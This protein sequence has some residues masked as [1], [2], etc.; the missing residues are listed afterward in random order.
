MVEWWG[1]VWPQLSIS[2]VQ[3]SRTDERGLGAGIWHITALEMAIAD[4]V[5][6]AL[7]LQD[8]ALSFDVSHLR[9][10][11]S[12]NSSWA[13]VLGNII[14]QL[15]SPSPVLLL[16]GHLIHPNQKWDTDSR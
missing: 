3:I 9:P 2:R 5:D 13:T 4:D 16:G 14:A 8:D 6:F 1:A 10:Q 12:P 7:I 11:F 15:P